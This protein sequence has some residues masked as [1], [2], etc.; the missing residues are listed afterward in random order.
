MAEGD[1]NL[2]YQL[3]SNGHPAS[4]GPDLNPDDDIN[5]QSLYLSDSRI[6]TR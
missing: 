2:G 5:N 3:R 4:A 6:D 1:Q